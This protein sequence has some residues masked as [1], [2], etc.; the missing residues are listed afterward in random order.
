MLLINYMDQESILKNELIKNLNFLKKNI[1]NNTEIEISIE[2]NN[3]ELLKYQKLIKYLLYKSEKNN[4]SLKMIVDLDIN[5]NYDSKSNSNYRITVHDLTNINTFIQNNNLIKNNILFS[6]IASKIADTDE[7]FSLI[8]KINS[9]DNYI[10][11]NEYNS[12][13]KLSYENEIEHKNLD[14]IKYI[15]DIDINNIK[16]RFKQRLS[17]IIFEDDNYSIKID[18]TDV[19]SSNKL[20]Y[21][22]SELSNYELEL[23]L[24]IKNDKNFN[25]ISNDIF[26]TISNLY[27]DLFKF[28]NETNFIIKN[29]EKNTVIKTLNKLCYDENIEYKDLP[30]TPTTSIELHHL[31][32]D[33]VGN[34]NV[35]DK[36]DGERAF[37]MIFE[38]NCY[39]INMN[40][41]VKKIK[42]NV[43]S[44]YN[45][46]II[47][48]EY[49]YI[50]KYKKF[51]FL[52]FDIIFL[53][54]NDIRNVSVLNTRLNNLKM[55]LKDVFDVNLKIG[56][57]EGDYNIDNIL[58]FNND[59]MVS[60]LDQLNK[61]LNKSTDLNIIYGKYMA[62]TTSISLRSDIFKLSVDM[63]NYYLQ[64]APYV[65][66]G[67]IYTP[68]DQIY[69]KK[70][71]KF[72][73]LRW[74]PAN[75]NSIDFYIKFEKNPRDNKIYTVFDK[76]TLNNIDEENKKDGDL[77]A[78]EKL[79]QIINLYVGQ[80]Q[81]NIEKPILFKPE[82][83]LSQTYVMIENGFPR[84]FENNIILDSTVVEFIYD[85]SE[86][87]N[88]KWKPLRTRYDKTFFV[89]NYQKKYGNYYI[90]A[91]KIWNSIKNPI[92]IEDLVLLSNPTT[93]DNHFKYL[94]NKL[95][96][97]VIVRNDAYY[98]LKS[99]FGKNMT[100]FINFIKSN[101]I[102][103][104]CSIKDINYSTKK[105]KLNVL[106]LAIGRGGD[107][108]KYY[109]SNVNSVVGLDV[110]EAGLFSGADAALGRYNNLRKKYPNFTKINFIVA[111]SGLKLDL[112]NQRN[113]GI[114]NSNNIKLLKQYFGED[115]NSTKYETFNTIV[116]N[117][118]VHYFLKDSNSFDNFCYNVNKYLSNNGYFIATTLDGELLFEDL[119]NNNGN[120]KDSIILESGEKK[121]LYDIKQLYASNIDI[122]NLKNDD[123]LGL[124][125]D[126]FIGIFMEEKNY[127]TEY[128]VIPNYF[129]KQLQDKC[130]LTLIETNLFSNI[131]YIYEDFFKNCTDYESSYVTKKIFDN[132]KKFY[133][134]NLNS[135][136][137]T[138][139]Y[140]NYHRYYIF[141]KNN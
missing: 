2:K 89:Q 27:I 58:K 65:L 93:S 115:E 55:V 5:Y 81:N 133:Q 30:S 109:H 72:S 18:L 86:N 28:I 117:L 108:L 129:I 16:F 13:M 22:N 45:L 138:F 105:I 141:Q 20:S 119:K 80:L 76:S 116:C 24:F 123:F 19:K 118:A 54:E 122:K 100:Y 85:E 34:Y 57:F 126:V 17:L 42:T 26:N 69:T 61:L 139:N 47:D 51:L 35:V 131:Y 10:N 21:I 59:N 4:Y 39:I 79:Y 92:T 63:W 60:H 97:T 25:K 31:V 95:T 36:A 73:I 3:I 12:K 53:K 107:L 56:L 14:S 106:D 111:D 114:Y 40:L 75:K 71:S 46:T 67:L 96:K 48:G 49:L 1:K 91:K 99:D 62:F 103:I 110:N 128:L 32:E 98:Q 33:L 9:Y 78:D 132:I 112:D 88:F 83:N 41:E 120:I 125:I 15:D 90:F 94:Q 7:F 52:A 77:I 102:S 140:M 70:K 68:I 11:L 38:N 82:D 8:N 87:S 104:Y 127:T 74:K 84:D 43:N 64:K 137:A 124:A 101:L 121:T 29:S 135:K 134:E 6:T 50:S 37:L 44:E 136:T 66:D 130:N 23:E 113:V